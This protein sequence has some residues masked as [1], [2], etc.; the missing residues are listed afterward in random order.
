MMGYHL[1]GYAATGELPGRHGT[2]FPS[3]APYQAFAT[4][5]G[6]ILVAAGN[7][8]AFASLCAVLGVPEL[9]ADPRYA[10]NAARV[11][12]RDALAELLAPLIAAGT[13]DGWLEQFAAAN[14]PAAPIQD[15]REVAEAPQTAALGLM[16]ALGGLPVA[17][18]P[19]SVDGERVTHASAAPPLG[20]D[21]EAVLREA[22]YSD[23]TIRELIADGIVRAAA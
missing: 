17:A 7:D 20:R 4:S 8:R 23:Q 1:S 3:I 9:V 16:Q 18:L 2:G 11:G 21:T 10:T 19:V 14:I 13:R 12:N 6:E 22:G 5:D 15:V